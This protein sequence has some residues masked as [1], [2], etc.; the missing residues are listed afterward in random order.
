MCQQYGSDPIAFQAGSWPIGHPTLH[1]ELPVQD[2]GGGDGDF[3]GVRRHGFGREGASGPAHPDLCGCCRGAEDLDGAFLGPVARAGLNHSGRPEPCA[4]SDSHD[5][6][7]AVRVAGRPAQAHA[8]PR[9]AADVVEQGGGAVVLA[10]GKV[11]SSVA[12]EVAQGASALLALD[13]NPAFVTGH[14]TKCSAAIAEKQQ[15]ASGIVARGL[16]L[17]AEE[18]LADDGVFVAVAVEVADGDSEGGRE[19]GLVRQG[20]RL[21]MV[22]AVEEEGGFEPIDFPV[23][24]GGGGVSEDVV[25]AGSGV[26]GKGGK[27]AGEGGDLF[28]EAVEGLEGGVTAQRVPRSRPRSNRRRPHRSSRRSRFGLGVSDAFGSAYCGPNWWR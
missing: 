8:Q 9:G 28:A 12:V 22:A 11:I 5:G 1:S 25:D 17:D 15:S 2:S 20:A 18:V 3:A 24:C 14:R 23:S 21:E 13:A 16:G 27:P 10:D 19:L 6:A 26:I 7:E 4:V